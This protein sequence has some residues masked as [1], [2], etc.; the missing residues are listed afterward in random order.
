MRE[1]KRVSCLGGL[2]V[3]TNATVNLLSAICVM[4]VETV[5]E[6]FNANVN[7]FTKVA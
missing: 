3:R 7:D 1:T 6:G 4:T 5:M 2:L